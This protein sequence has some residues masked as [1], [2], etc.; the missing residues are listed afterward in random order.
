MKLD[1]KY[2]EFIEPH[3]KTICNQI[4]SDKPK[5]KHIKPDKLDYREEVKVSNTKIY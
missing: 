3:S 2:N 4:I 1:C 5:A